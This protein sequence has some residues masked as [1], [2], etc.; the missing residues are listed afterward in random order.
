LLEAIAGLLPVDS[1]EIRLRDQLLPAHRR[2]DVIFYLPDGVRPYADQ[3]GEL[4]AS[5]A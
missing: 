1:G 2:R 4:A 3:F 5:W